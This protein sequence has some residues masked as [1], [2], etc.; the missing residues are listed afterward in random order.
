MSNLIY[1]GNGQF[2]CPLCG[3]P[4]GRPINCNSYIRDRIASNTLRWKP[5]YS[6]NSY[7]RLFDDSYATRNILVDRLYLG[8][9]GFNRN[10]ILIL[11]RMSIPLEVVY[12]FVMNTRV[13]YR[14]EYLAD[15]SIRGPCMNRTCN[16]D[17]YCHR[18]RRWRRCRAWIWYYDDDCR[19]IRVDDYRC[20]NLT[21]SRRARCYAHTY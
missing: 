20:S 11:H 18:H 2:A 5:R 17:V 3:D 8:D 21:L 1:L 14:C 13:N 9:T 10:L 16:P 15:R 12:S 6:I 7:P 4:I 19:H